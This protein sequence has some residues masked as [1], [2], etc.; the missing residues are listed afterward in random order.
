[1]GAPANIALFAMLAGDFD[2]HPSLRQFPMH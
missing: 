1:L 2:F